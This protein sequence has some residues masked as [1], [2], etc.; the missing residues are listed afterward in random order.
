MKLSAVAQRGPEGLHRH[1]RPGRAL[2]AES[3]AGL[4]SAQVRVKD[5]AHVLYG[6]AYFDDAEPEKA[7]YL[8][9][10]LEWQDVKRTVQTWLKE[11]SLIRMVC[12]EEPFS[13]RFSQP[14][15]DM[16]RLHPGRAPSQRYTQKV[17]GKK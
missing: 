17:S 10:K 7:P 11:F 3:H 4:L 8:V 16:V 5:I 6:L 14:T 15:E 2:H 12:L 13:L 1:L 9:W